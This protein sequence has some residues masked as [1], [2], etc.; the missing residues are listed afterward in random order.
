MSGGKKG[1]RGG[2]HP[3]DRY[4]ILISELVAGIE[5]WAADE[6][7]VHPEAWEA[8]R[9]AKATLGTPVLDEQQEEGLMHEQVCATD[10]CGY[11][12]RVHAKDSV[13]A[14]PKLFARGW[15]TVRDRVGDPVLVCPV[16]VERRRREN[17]KG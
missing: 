5:A 13:M 3:M 7:G 1:W 8:Y 4:V 16:C 14:V 12:E 10:G 2:M 9:Q 11:V 15:E 17:R 6:D